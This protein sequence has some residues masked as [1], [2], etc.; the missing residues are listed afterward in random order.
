[1]TVSV[2]KWVEILFVNYSLTFHATISVFFNMGLM[3]WITNFWVLP[4]NTLWKWKITVKNVFDMSYR[5]GSHRL[6]RHMWV[7]SLPWKLIKMSNIE[8]KKSYIAPKYLNTTTNATEKLNRKLQRIACKSREGW[9]SLS[10]KLCLFL[11]RSFWCKYVLLQ[12]T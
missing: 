1:M 2:R 10:H 4:F 6:W 3:M 5:T 9:S 7:W 8:T 12:Y 11:R